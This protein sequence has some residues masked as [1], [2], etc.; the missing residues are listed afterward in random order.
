MRMKTPRKG[1][2]L[3]DTGDTRIRDFKSGV[4]LHCHTDESRETLDFVPYYASKIPLLSQF[5]D[6]VRESYTARNGEVIDFARAYWTP[7]LPARAVLDAEINQIQK[8]LGLAS[9]VSITDHDNI[10]ACTHLQV[11]HPEQEIP[12]SLEWTVPFGCGFFHIGVHNLPP[13]SSTE[14]WALL[15]GY[16]RNPE[17][18]RLTDLLDLLCSHQD[19]LLVLNHPLWD[20]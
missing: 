5:L 10:T 16:T 17:S 18:S 19:T 1:I 4:S 20:I 8:G 3:L 7:P 11:L 9:L 6:R 13:A 12:V 14:I 2:R 15:T